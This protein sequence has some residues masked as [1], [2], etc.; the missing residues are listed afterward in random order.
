VLCCRLRSVWRPGW[1]RRSS[2]RERRS[3]YCADTIS[4]HLCF[5][6]CMLSTMSVLQGHLG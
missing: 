3:E 5:A 6:L 1:S 4:L 2:R